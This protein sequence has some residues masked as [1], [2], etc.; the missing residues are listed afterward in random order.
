MIER[1]IKGGQKTIAYKQLGLSTSSGTG[2]CYIIY[3]NLPVDS[4]AMYTP[5]YDNVDHAPLR[6]LDF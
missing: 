4:Q 3:V 1:H 5:G 6:A 2:S